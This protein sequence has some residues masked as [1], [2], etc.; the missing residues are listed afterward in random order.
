MSGVS[1]KNCKDYSTSYFDED[2]FTYHYKNC[3]NKDD[4]DSCEVE[5][6]NEVEHQKNKQTKEE[7]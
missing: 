1:F 3:K 2:S 4:L 7:E 6:Y 5:S